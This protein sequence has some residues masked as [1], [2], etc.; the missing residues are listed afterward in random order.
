[1]SLD[2]SL[3]PSELPQYLYKIIPISSPPPE[4]LPE[5]LAL[6]PLDAKDGYIHTSTSIQTPPTAD[7]YFSNETQLYIAKI[8]YEGVRDVVKWEA[9]GSGTFAHIYN[10]GRLGKAEISEVV[11][12]TRQGEQ[13]WKQVLEGAL[14]GW[15]SH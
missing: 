10:G 14:E 2:S 12:W 1:M 3:V 6:S 4:P 11:L 9:A 15:L 7:R 13:S 8:P 5:V